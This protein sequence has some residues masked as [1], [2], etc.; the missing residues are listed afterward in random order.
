MS[1]TSPSELNSEII[2]SLTNEKRIRRRKRRSRFA[3]LAIT[4]LTLLCALLAVQQTVAKAHRMAPGALPLA[5][6]FTQ[7]PNCDNRPQL[8]TIDCIVLHSTVE[9]TTEGTMGI[10]LDPKKKVSAHF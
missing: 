10:F 3:R 1:P 2:G 4:A 9:V 6:A 7:S 5:Y 8:A